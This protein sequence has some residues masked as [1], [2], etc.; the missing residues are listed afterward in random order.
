MGQPRSELVAVGG[1]Y[2]YA[3][4]GEKAEE[5]RSAAEKI[6]RL[7]RKTLESIIAIGNEL[8]AV[9]ALLP[10]GQFLHWLKTEFA[11]QR[12]A[13]YN[14]LSVAARFKVPI[15]GSL[16]I[17]PTAA[18]LLAAP[19]VPDEARQT[20]IARAQAGERITL[21]VAREIVAEVRAGKMRPVAAEQFRRRI[22]KLLQRYREELH[23]GNRAELARE[24]PAFA[25]ELEENVPC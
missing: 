17:Q 9:K 1:A 13:A 16:P 8:L 19:S 11:W 25:A 23:P 10:H 12:S 4:V 5:V 6:R 2:D 3:L 18:F 7:L 21:T 15:I 20:A 24:L 14:F 22:A